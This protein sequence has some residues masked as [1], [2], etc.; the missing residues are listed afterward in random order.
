MIYLSSE[1]AAIRLISPDLDKAWIPMG[2]EPVIGRLT[3]G[4]NSE[5]TRTAEKVTL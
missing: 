1:E 4:L 3:A 5:S 2:G